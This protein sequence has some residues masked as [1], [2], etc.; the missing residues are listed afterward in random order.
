MKRIYI[1]VS[2]EEYNEIKIRAKS[3]GYPL[4]EDYVKSTL[5]HQRKQEPVD[6][7]RLE[8]KIQ[9]MIN[10]FTAK[11]DELA[12]RIA[13]LEE[14]VSSLGSKQVVHGQVEKRIAP[15]MVENRGRNEAEGERTRVQGEREVKRS[16]VEILKEKGYM[17]GSYD[18]LTKPDLFFEKLKSVEAKILKASDKWVAIDKDFYRTFTENLS[19]I[20]VS[21]SAEAEK[22]LGSAGP[23]FRELTKLGIIVYDSSK[24]RWVIYD[25]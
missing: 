14:T 17:I 13:Q 16:A 24:K 20:E 1:E 21:D 25:K 22:K 6:L 23:L 18:K 4:V 10:P 5:M 8:R 7:T 11:I 15:G 9:D 12:R 2:D 19:H 3:E